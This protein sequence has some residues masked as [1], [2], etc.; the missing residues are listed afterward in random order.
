[1]SLGAHQWSLG[2]RPD[3]ASAQRSQC[4]YG[5]AGAGKLFTS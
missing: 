1:M 5:Q 2:G 4:R 3:F